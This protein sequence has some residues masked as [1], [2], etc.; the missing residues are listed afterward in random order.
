MGI[1]D[2]SAITSKG[3]KYLMKTSTFHT[4]AVRQA[5][6]HGFGSLLR[7]LHFIASQ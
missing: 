5:Y 6:R 2:L 7:P 3:Q 4:E 1:I